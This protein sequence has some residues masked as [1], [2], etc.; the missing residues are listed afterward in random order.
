MI[1]NKGKVLKVEDG[2][3]IGHIG[4]DHFIVDLHV[5]DQKGRGGTWPADRMQIRYDITV[6]ICFLELD[7]F[8]IK[9]LVISSVR[10]LDDLKPFALVDLASSW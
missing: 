3:H 6:I 2:V 4:L 7:R 1:K 8:R 10:T 9:G 5:L